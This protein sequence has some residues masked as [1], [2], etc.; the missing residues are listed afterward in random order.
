VHRQQLHVNNR[1]YHEGNCRAA[2]PSNELEEVLEDWDS[3]CEG[4]GK[5]NYRDSDSVA[6]KSARKARAG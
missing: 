3:D 1:R 2:H 5:E 6:L 4:I